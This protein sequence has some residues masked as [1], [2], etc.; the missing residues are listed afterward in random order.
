MCACVC[1]C[2]YVCVYVR[3]NVLV[4]S[5]NYVFVLVFACVGGRSLVLTSLLVSKSSQMFSGRL[6]T[7]GKFLVLGVW[8]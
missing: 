1:G 2:V 3:A 8:W 7:V 4:C 6:R 5:G